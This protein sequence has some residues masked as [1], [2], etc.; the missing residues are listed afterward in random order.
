MAKIGPYI[1]L[2]LL[3]LK[4]GLIF[5]KIDRSTNKQYL[6]GSNFESFLDNTI[7]WFFTSMK[8][9]FWTSCRVD[10]GP[11][12]SVPSIHPSATGISRERFQFFQNLA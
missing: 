4:H 8:D 9:I 12:N 7:N 2:L 5:Y 1:R 3:L 11:I 10:R 6:C